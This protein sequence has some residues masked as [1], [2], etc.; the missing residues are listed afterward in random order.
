MPQDPVD[1]ELDT[2][3]I[4]RCITELGHDI[5]DESDGEMPE[6]EDPYASFLLIPQ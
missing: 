3:K 2:E 1:N 4:D 5:I 6:L